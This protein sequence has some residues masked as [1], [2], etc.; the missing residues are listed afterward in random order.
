MSVVN[1]LQSFI[2]FCRFF[3]GAF[4]GAFYNKCFWVFMVHF[5]VFFVL[6][7]VVCLLKRQD[8]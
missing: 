6:L 4:C 3:S 5:V 7:R 2:K 8:E 1:Y